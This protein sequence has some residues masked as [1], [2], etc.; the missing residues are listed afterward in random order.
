[1]PNVP[2]I[3]LMCLCFFAEYAA[4]HDWKYHDE[5]HWSPLCKE[6]TH[7]S[8]IA[9]YD[10]S[11]KSMHYVPFN[12]TGY[13][14]T[15]TAKM[16]NNGHSA[17]IRP[18][19]KNNTPEIKGGGLPETYQMDHLH[20]HWQSEHTINDYR[21]PL[22]LHIVHYAKQYGNLDEAKLHVGGVAVVAVLFDLSPDDDEEIQP[23]FDIL[24]SIQ[25]DLNDPKELNDFVVKRFIPRDH[26]GFYR[27][28]G[29]LTTPGC[30]EG[31]I[32]TIFTQTM[33]ISRH[34]VETFEKIR[35]VDHT[36]LKENFRSLQP[37]NDRTVYIKISPI[38]HPRSTADTK[39]ASVVAYL[40]PCIFYILFKN[41]S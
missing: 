9:L 4:G 5:E 21:F 16:K 24:E 8:P 23:I 33:P 10:F 27:Y 29:S 1:M 6:G 17:E 28:E 32:W 40:I 36:M 39:K 18:D 20:F 11:A 3:K 12:L 31:V 13:G 35:T 25:D 14:N 30:D 15:F 22:E 7:Q 26:A 38:P 2:V 41:N 37:L 34:Q 19:F